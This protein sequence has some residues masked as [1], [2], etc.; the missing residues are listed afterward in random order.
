MVVAVKNTYWDGPLISVVTPFYNHGKTLPETIASVLGQTFQD[1]EYII[2]NDGS[3]DAISQ[4]VFNGIDDQRI[5]KILQKNQGVAVARNHGI[6]EARG[7]YILCLDADDRIDPT[8]LEKAVTVLEL[9]PGVGIVYSH[10]HFFGI[11]EGVAREPEFNADILLEANI[12]HTASVFRKKDWERVGGY[13][14][15]L[16]FE[17]WEFWINLV[18]HGVVGQLIPEA[19]FYYRRAEQSRFID[20]MKKKDE[21]IRK[22]RSLHPR[23]HHNLQRFRNK[24]PMRYVLDPD[25]TYVN[26]RDVESYL[27]SAPRKRNV[28]LLMPW[29]T[30][31]GAETLVYN[32]CSQLKDDFDISIITGL[33]SENELEYR[34]REICDSYYS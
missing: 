15:N 28:L 3:T 22:I 26:L 23:Y 24:I 7:K 19:L 31:G 1:F 2:V 6:S 29:L 20:D 33:K 32:Y 11:E 18:E 21:N 34:F 5:R 12:L 10:V 14:S 8:Y 16:G 17:D 27:E 25:T 30:F 13:K 4:E 9:N